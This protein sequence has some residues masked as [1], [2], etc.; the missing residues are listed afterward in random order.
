MAFVYWIKIPTHHNIY[1]EGYI[2]ITSRTVRLRFNNHRYA[3]KNGDTTRLYNAMRKYKDLIEVV[4]IFE[5]SLD[6]CL[7]L[8]HYYRP[9][10]NVGWN[11]GVGGTAPSLGVKM[12]DHVKEILRSHRVGK[13]ASAE[14]RER[15]SKA[16]IGRKYSEES[17]KKMSESAK[18]VVR[19]PW[20][21]P[22]ANKE[23]W[24]KA[25]VIFDIFQKENNITEASKILSCESCKLI[26][27]FDKFKSGWVPYEDPSWVS[28]K[29]SYEIGNNYVENRD[30]KQ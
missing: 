18:A 15:I 1:T 8:E 12:P 19:Y 16:G 6:E 10:E 3:A 25:D 24:F 2:G 9:S 30:T 26:S 4:T 22:R 28:F 14:T 13:T 27:I 7:Y 21:N 20:K 23:I 29:N 17:R 5:G 11:N